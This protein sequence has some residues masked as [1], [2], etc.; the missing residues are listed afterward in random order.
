M[1]TTDH[2][3]SA[4]RDWNGATTEEGLDVQGRSGYRKLRDLIQ[5]ALAEGDTSKGW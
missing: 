5:N 2:E 1:N 3:E 4:V